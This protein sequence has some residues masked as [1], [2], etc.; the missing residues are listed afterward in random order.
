MSAAVT[1]DDHGRHA[2]VPVLSDARQRLLV[3]AMA[4]LLVQG[5]G[6]DGASDTDA[7]VVVGQGAGAVADVGSTQ[8]EL[9]AFLDAQRHRGDGWAPQTD[10]PREASDPVSPHGR[11]QV[12]R[13][14]TLRASQAAGNGADFDAPAHETGSM[15]VKEF[16]DDADDLLGR[17][18]MLKLAGDARRWAYYCSGPDARC[19][20]TAPTYGIDAE[21]SCSFCHGGLVFTQGP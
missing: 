13:N 15:V 6:D 19:M 11:V 2:C 3:V 7:S 17:A 4:G 14:D 16:Y 1:D 12:W 18:A 8:E 20:D 5:C 10:E 21:A 9:E